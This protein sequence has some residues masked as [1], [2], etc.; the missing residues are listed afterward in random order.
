MAEEQY[1]DLAQAFAIRDST[2]A[3]K[4]LDQA[5]RRIANPDR[6]ARFRFVR[7]ALSPIRAI[8]DSVFASFQDSV[9]RRRSSWVTE[10]NRALHHPLRADQAEGYLRPSLDLLDEIKRTG[11]IFFP[12][13]WLESTLGGH[14]SATAADIVTRFLA[15]R[16]DLAPR[17][18]AKLLQTADGLF[19]AARVVGQDGPR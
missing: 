9:I 2:Q 18:K 19:R 13:G 15:D 14:Q 16:P 3:G 17:L 6:V 11:D 4:I 7:R 1:T 5:E 8:R 12:I 10:A